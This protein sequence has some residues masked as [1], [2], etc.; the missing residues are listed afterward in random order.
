MSVSLLSLRMD[1]L[2]VATFGDDLI[3]AMSI[4]LRTL[5]QASVIE[6]N[7]CF[8]SRNW[9][10]KPMLVGSQGTCSSLILP[11]SRSAKQYIRTGHVVRSNMTEIRPSVF[12][13]L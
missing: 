13:L 2:F 11:W 3:F 12:T 1:V 6:T 9:N 8:A 4:A 7:E 10:M 5:L